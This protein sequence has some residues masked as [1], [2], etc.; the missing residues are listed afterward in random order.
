MRKWFAAAGMVIA[1]LGCGDVTDYIEPTTHPITQLNVGGEW[2]LV[3]EG[4]VISPSFRI[5]LYDSD[6]KCLN[7]R[8]SSFDGHIESDDG[9]F[10][11]PPVDVD[12]AYQEWGLFV[13]GFV[14][15]LP[16]CYEECRADPYPVE[17]ECTSDQQFVVLGTPTGGAPPQGC[18]APPPVETVPLDITV[19]LPTELLE[20]AGDGIM[21]FL[22]F[23]CNTYGFFDLEHGFTDGESSFRIAA[24]VGCAI[25]EAVQD[26]LRITAHRICVKVSTAT[27]SCTSAPQTVSEDSWQIYTENCGG[28]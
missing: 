21:W 9:A 27:V 11:V 23:D 5:D 28:S 20:V 16:G 7:V 8:C 17:L 18:A 13:A 12:C 2:P 25:D 24:E 4:F 19:E 22:G 15:F 26:D 10:V 1:A 6:L 14:E 3:A